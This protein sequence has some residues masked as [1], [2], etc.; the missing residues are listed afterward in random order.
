MEAHPLR[1]AEPRF[2]QRPVLPMGRAGAA[3]DSLTATLRAAVHLGLR[4]LQAAGQPEK[5]KIWVKALNLA[6]RSATPH[7]RWRSLKMKYSAPRNV[8][9]TAKTRNK[10]KTGNLVSPSNI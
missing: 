9:E 3:G 10:V 8:A 1:G 2:A 6:P 7:G 5:A 4:Y